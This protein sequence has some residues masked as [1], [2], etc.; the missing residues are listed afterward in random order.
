MKPGS[1]EQSIPLYTL[2]MMRERNKQQITIKSNL[3]DKT[4]KLFKMK[5]YFDN[6]DEKN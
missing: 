4:T 2:M 3:Q 6:D 5:G 1:L